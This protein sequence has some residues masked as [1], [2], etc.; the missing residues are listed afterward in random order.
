[1]FIKRLGTAKNYKI[2][3]SVILLAA[4]VLAVTASCQTNTGSDTNNGNID[5]GNLNQDDFSNGSEDEQEPSKILPNLPDVYYDGHE[6]TILSMSN[7]DGV[8]DDFFAQEQTG[9]II[10]DAIYL[11]NTYVEDSYGVRI[12]TVNTGHANMGS[13]IAALRRTVAAGDHDYDAAVL[14]AYNASAS[15]LEGLLMDLNSMPPL[16]LSRPWWDQRANEDLEIKGRMFFTTGDISRA[17]SDSVWVI[18]FNKKLVQDY[19]ISED[20]YQLVQSGGWT[21]DKL[22]E[23]ARMV[24][25]DLNGDGEMNQNDRFG[26]ITSDDIMQCMIN[27]IGE[28]SAVIN[29]DG[30]IELSLYNERTISV[31]DKLS[32]LIWDET[33]VFHLQRVPSAS[34]EAM[35]ENEQA[36]FIPTGTRMIGALRAMETNFGILPMPKLDER[37]SSYS[38]PIITWWS[39]FLCAPVLQ[40]DAERTA[41]ILEAL[42]AESRYTL[43]PAYYDRSLIGQHV[44]DDESEEML[45]IIFATRIYDLGW[46]YQIGGYDM[47]MINIMRERR[48]DFASTFE[49]SLGR[50]E[51]DIQRIND[52]F[53]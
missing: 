38:N 32:A 23:F 27:T 24:S 22:S 6:F 36:L 28:K 25:A 43:R 8:W 30:Y 17:M 13:G 9:E 41:V 16:D 51:R 18:L 37:Q 52:L 10:N 39:V 11:R 7:E 29:D 5:S 21:W 3:I 48:G 4:L 2:I 42:A 50:A 40:A 12:N 47:G 49:R 14:S 34:G 15:D 44:R 35:F 46:Y 20:P 45:D 31:F 1:M 53:S 19:G 26:L 33:V